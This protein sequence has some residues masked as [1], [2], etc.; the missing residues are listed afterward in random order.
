M[1]NIKIAVINASTVIT[2]DKEVKKVVDAL[3]IQ[4]QRDFAP[5]WGVDAD[6]RVV[7]KGKK[8]AAGEWWLVILDN[9]DQAG[10]LGYHDVTKDG[11]PLG[12][13]FAKTDQTYGQQ[14]SGTASHELLEMLA[15]PNINLTVFE[16]QTA[17]GR[18]YA[19]E[20]CD[21]C[22]A[23]KFG[24][25]INGVL[26]SDFVYPSWFESFRTSG[27]QFDFMKKIKSP[28]QLLAGGY[29]GFYDV[30]AGSGWQQQTA[31]KVNFRSRPPVGSRRE[32][33]SVPLG[34]RIASTV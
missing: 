27:T 32:R 29:I 20:V 11:L 17:G 24:Y 30:Q 12:K 3:Q 25:Q 31:E 8:P 26:M 1:A 28:F 4:V 19:Y 34:Q 22:E 2:D 7:P 9:S 23:E 21:A 33:R 5:A 10:A 15:D 18:L 13:I 14:W 16:E 6:L